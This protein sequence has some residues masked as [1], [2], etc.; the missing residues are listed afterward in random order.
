MCSDAKLGTEE[1]I[2]IR[3]ALFS[4]EMKVPVYIL[5]ALV[6]F[7][8]WSCKKGNDPDAPALPT[9][10]F[11]DG[12]IVFRRGMGIMSRIVLHADG[13]GVYS[14]TGI[15]RREGT[16]WYVIHAVPDEPDF[17]GDPDRVKKEP[18]TRFFASDRAVRGMVVRYEGRPE[19]AARA[20]ASAEEYVRRGTLFDHKYN[21]DDTTEMYCTELVNHVYKKEG[22]DLSEGRMSKINLPAVGGTYLLPTDLAENCHLKIIFCFP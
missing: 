8:S 16:E 7:A 3:F 11:N 13:D 19:A 17:D 10:L 12:D 20:A 15:L 6:V 1:Q 22:I 4:E 18:V 9:E 21:L 2:N 14:H 5:T